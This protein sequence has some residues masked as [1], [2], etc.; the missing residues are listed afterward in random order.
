VGY[1]SDYDRSGYGEKEESSYRR[2][3]H[4]SSAAAI[5][6]DSYYSSFS[7]SPSRGYSR[8]YN[9]GSC[10]DDGCDDDCRMAMWGCGCI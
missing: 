10:N 4:S 8:D 7:E 1:G 2:S 6:G 3:D 9:H 5:D